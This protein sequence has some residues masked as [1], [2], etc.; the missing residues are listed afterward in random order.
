MLSPEFSCS[1]FNVACAALLC[2][3]RAPSERAQQGLK[4]HEQ[5]ELNNLTSPGHG[6]DRAAAA[7]GVRVQHTLHWPGRERPGNFGKWQHAK[8]VPARYPR[9]PCSA[10]AG[11]GGASVRGREGGNHTLPKRPRGA[12]WGALQEIQIWNRT[13]KSSG[14]WKIACSLKL[15]KTDLPLDEWYSEYRLYLLL[16]YKLRNTENWLAK[17]LPWHLLKKRVS[18]LTV[19]VYPFSA[20]GRQTCWFVNSPV[21]PFSHPDSLETHDFSALGAALLTLLVFVGFK[22][23]F[24]MDMLCMWLEWQ[25][26]FM[27]L[28][29]LKPIFCF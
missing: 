16:F 10:R 6:T 5:K 23:K 3:L 19:Y 14:L 12:G 13:I 22:L 18:V 21:T 1:G 28:F 8:Q 2:D 27:D 11:G 17:L 9:C 20:L 4:Q 26:L 24:R 29:I 25:V 15:S 7:V